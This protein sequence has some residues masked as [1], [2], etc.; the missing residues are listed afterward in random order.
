MVTYLMYFAFLT[1]EVKCGTAVLDTADCQIGPSLMLA[2]RASVELFR[3]V[4][5]RG[6]STASFSPFLAGN[7]VSLCGCM[8]SAR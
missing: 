1:C 5:S 4:K 6:G 8:E 7:T 3:L 2:A